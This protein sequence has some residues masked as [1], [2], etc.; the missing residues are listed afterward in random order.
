MAAAANR[1]ERQ[2]VTIEII[3]VEQGSPEW[4]LC[5]SGI[6]TASCFDKV[7]AKG[8][9]G[10]ESKTRRDYLYQLADEAIYRDPVETYTNANMERG[11]LWE[12]EARDIYALEND[13][14]PQQV[15]FV[16]N[17]TFN[18]GYSPDSLIGM[19]GQLEIKTMFPRLW[20]PHVIHGSHPAEFTP[21][22]QGGLWVGEREWVD[23]MIYWPRRRPYITRVYRNEP[24]IAQLAKAVEAFNGELAATIDALCTKFDLRSQLEAAAAR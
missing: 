23:L 2:K 21:Q 5:R 16:R 4:F 12:A 15:G 18:A 17:H 19:N 9:G 7:L 6:P 8:R 10:E 11:R 22:L 1:K 24:Y 13:V 3:D 14:V 20:V